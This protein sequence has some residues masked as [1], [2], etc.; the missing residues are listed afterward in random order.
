MVKS[1]HKALPELVEAGILSHAKATEIEAFYDQADDA[2]QQRLLVIFGSL[3]ALLVGLGLILIVA[4]NWDLFPK[5]VKLLLALFPTLLGQGIAAYV[6]A[7]QPESRGWREGSAIFLTLALG[8]SLS[9]ISQIYQLPGEL[10]GYLLTWLL[11]ALPIMYVLRSSMASLLYLMGVTGYACQIGYFGDDGGL[12]VWSYWALLAAA[13]PFYLQLATRRPER[14][15]TRFHHWV[16][17]L[18]LVITGGVVVSESPVLLPALYMSLFG[19]L[20]LIG[21][22]Q[23]FADRPDLGNSYQSLGS[24]G[25][26]VIL[27][28]CSFEA[29]WEELGHESWAFGSGEFLYT[30]LLVLAAGGLL[31]LQFRDRSVSH[32]DPRKVLFGL[33]LV[34]YQIGQAAPTLATVMVNLLVLLF[35]VLTIRNGVQARHLG[36]LNYGL[37]ILAALTVCRFFDVDLPFVFKG[38]AFVAVGLGFFFANYW[39]IRQRKRVQTTT[40]AQ[41]V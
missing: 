1:L 16:V 13:M 32:F 14:N 21:D 2:P 27:I 41:T 37:L 9:L 38:L 23:L 28:V 30:S 36:V 12:P 7:Q 3:G 33:F 34:V 39:M 17:A 31:L 29:V 19:L 6:L 11:L 10:G 35:G 8:A 15:D 22:S 26:S 40:D 4:H 24:L 18:S 5:S 25:S 20:Y